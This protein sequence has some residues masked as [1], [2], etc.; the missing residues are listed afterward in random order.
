MRTEIKIGLIAGAVGLVLNICVST[1]LGLCG[2]FLSLIVGAAAGL[3]A[4]RQGKPALKSEGRK[5]GAIAGAIAGALMIIGQL[6]GGLGAL[7]LAQFSG[8][9]IPFG[10]VPPPTADAAS[11]LIYYLSGIGTGL[12]FGLIGTLLA[13]LAGLAAGHLATTEIIDSGR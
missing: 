9:K 2:P 13:A 10:E 7:I 1:V 3:L 4:V 12:C 11:Q 8:V 5:M 6:I